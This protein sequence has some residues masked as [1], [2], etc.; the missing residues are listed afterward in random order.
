MS[1]SRNYMYI[2]HTHI[3]TIPNSLDILITNL[4]KNLCQASATN[5]TTLIQPIL[6]AHRK[7]KELARLMKKKTLIARK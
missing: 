5:H 3:I 1:D 6:I 7:F 4:Q 2:E